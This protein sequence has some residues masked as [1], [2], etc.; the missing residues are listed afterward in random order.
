MAFSSQY[1]VSSKIKVY[2]LLV[3]VQGQNEEQR[4]SCLSTR[5]VQFQNLR[6][7]RLNTRS[8]QKS[9]VMTLSSHYKVKMKNNDPLV[10]VQGPFNSKFKTFP[11]QYNVKMKNND[12]LVLVQGLGLYPRTYFILKIERN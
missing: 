4:P 8:V 2:D 9:K 5:S 6:S 10:L 11:S 3:S 1:K 12:P 7:S